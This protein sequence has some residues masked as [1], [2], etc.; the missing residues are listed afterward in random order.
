MARE[1]PHQIET[2]YDEAGN[3]IGLVDQYGMY[4]TEIKLGGDGAPQ[5]V[6]KLMWLVATARIELEK[7]GE[8]IDVAI[9][10][11]AG[12]DPAK[13]ADALDKWLADIAQR[14]GALKSRV[15]M[16]ARFL[17]MWQML[18]PGLQVS[19]VHIGREGPELDVTDLS[20]IMLVS[21]FADSWHEWQTEVS[22]THV[23]ALAGQA[24]AQGRAKGPKFR[25]ETRKAAILRHV[26]TSNHISD[27]C[28]EDV[29]IDL[30]KHG[31]KRVA[32]KASLLRAI[33]RIRRGQKDPGQRK[34]KST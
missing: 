34:P 11:A 9:I 17:M 2:L 28:F 7:N 16:A 20:K 25:A 26:G 10:E 13:A 22:K 18:G 12:A 5:Y 33:Q 6:Q 24:A 3:E 15:Q 4:R 19:T 27:R 23:L 1:I 32:S 30:K 14:H 29:N 31:L 21:C 8:Q